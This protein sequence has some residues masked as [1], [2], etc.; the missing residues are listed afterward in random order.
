M[1]AV[2][3]S[4]EIALQVLHAAIFGHMTSTASIAFGLVA[5]EMLKLSRRSQSIGR[6]W[7]GFTT[8]NHPWSRKYAEASIILIRFHMKSS[9]RSCTLL[10]LEA[11]SLLLSMC[12][13]SMRLL[14]DRSSSFFFRSIASARSCFFVSLAIA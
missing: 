7:V 9:S 4:N 3:I 1:C 13:V 8:P 10:Y 2:V 6:E 5:Y 11:M 14:Y 12:S